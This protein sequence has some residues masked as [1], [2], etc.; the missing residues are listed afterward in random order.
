VLGDNKSMRCSFSE[1][2]LMVVVGA[3][4]IL[5]VLFSELM[6]DERILAY[7]SQLKRTWFSSS[8]I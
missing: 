4:A 6:K 7:I 2:W 8:M 1:L 5:G 3:S